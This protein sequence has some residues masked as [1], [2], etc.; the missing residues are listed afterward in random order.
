MHR[1]L[2]S[3]FARG[4]SK[5]I[6]GKAIVPMEGRPMIGWPPAAARRSGLFAKIRVSADSDAI[7]GAVAALG[8]PVDFMRAASFADDVT[9]LLPGL[10]WVV[11]EFC[12]RGEHYDDVTL[13]YPTAV[14]L[15][16]DDLREEHALFHA[17]GARESVQA[18]VRYAMSVEYAL[19]RDG[20]GHLS[21]WMPDVLKQK[22][23]DLPS[24]LH[25]TGTFAI[26]SA[27]ELLADPGKLVDQQFLC[28]AMPRERGIDFDEPEDLD[29]ARLLLWGRLASRP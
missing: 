21:P 13:I 18:V 15:A 17:H 2:A 10:S 7:A 3:L 27:E 22:T 28:Y 26:I 25:D 23:Q 4:G 9:P 20:T 29:L 24:K 11:Q 16:P 19:L 5:C 6:P 14:M 8:L 12:S 1:F